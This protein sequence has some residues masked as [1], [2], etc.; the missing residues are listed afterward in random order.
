MRAAS[1]AEDIA[2]KKSKASAWFAGLRN[3]PRG[4]GYRLQRDA[5]PDMTAGELRS[6]LAELY[7]DKLK[8]RTSGYSISG[9]SLRTATASEA[10]AAAAD[11]YE[12]RRGDVSRALLC[13]VSGTGCGPSR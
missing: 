9:V 8:E 10:K 12:P 6:I 11:R 7:P 1:M 5:M 4:I 3:E 2:E 13:P